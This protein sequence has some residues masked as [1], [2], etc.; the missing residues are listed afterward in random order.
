MILSK[1]EFSTL[2]AL[3]SRLRAETEAPQ[4][5]I[6]AM[7]VILAGVGC[8]LGDMPDEPV[9]P[10]LGVWTPMS[11]PPEEGDECLINYD[12]QVYIGLWQNEEWLDGCDDRYSDQ[13]GITHW[14]PMPAL[15]A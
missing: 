11:T 4:K 7:D 15:P 2:H 6:N 3:L 14:M 13:D 12:G 9:K 5:Q 8:L 1:T 10:A